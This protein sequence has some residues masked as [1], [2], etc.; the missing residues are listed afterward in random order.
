MQSYLNNTHLNVSHIF[1]GKFGTFFSEFLNRQNERFEHRQYNSK[2]DFYSK[3]DIVNRISYFPQDK[4]SFL[5]SKLKILKACII[6]YTLLEAMN[7]VKKIGEKTFLHILIKGEDHYLQLILKNFIEENMF[8]L[9]STRIY[10]IE[11]DTFQKLIEN[12]TQETFDKKKYSTNDK[13]DIIFA[14]NVSTKLMEYQNIPNI[15]I[16]IDY[17]IYKLHTVMNVKE[18]NLFLTGQFYIQNVNT[19]LTEDPYFKNKKSL[20]KFRQT[21]L[22]KMKEELKEIISKFK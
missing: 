7:V 8:Y 18:M 3:L 21:I 20:K 16:F 4:T 11:K 15:E 10:N 9:T 19:F 6:A 5:N 1:K 13:K 12:D 2:N 17:L 14:Q 22:K